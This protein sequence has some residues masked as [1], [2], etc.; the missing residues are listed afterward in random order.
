MVPIQIH[1]SLPIL[2]KFSWKFY[3]RK[4]TER[5]QHLEFARVFTF[6]RSSSF[7]WGQTC[8]AIPTQKHRFIK[9]WQAI[10]TWAFSSNHIQ[11]SWRT[12][13]RLE[14]GTQFQPFHGDFQE[15]KDSIWKI[16]PCPPRKY[17]SISFPWKLSH[18]QWACWESMRIPN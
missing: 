9:S 2:S 17:C 11:M 10:S 14:T 5:I 13:S 3:Y 8:P 7:R 4:F 6:F 18:F 15:F 12:P 16:P 1:L